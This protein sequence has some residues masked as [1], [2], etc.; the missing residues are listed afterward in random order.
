MDVE[1]LITDS[2]PFLAWLGHWVNGRPTLPLADIV[3]QAGGPQH[4]A[5]LATDIIVG[6]CSVGALASPRVGGI[7]APTVRLFEDAHRLGIRHFVLTQDTHSENAVEFGS[8][9]PHCIG[10]SSESE[11]VPELK[12]LPFSDLFV[13]LPKNSVNPAM[14]TGFED[15]LVAHPEVTTFLVTG[16]CTDICVHQL[17]LYIRVRANAHDLRG[18]RVIV[19]IDCVDTYDLPVDVAVEQGIL[20]HPADLL[21]HVF[22]HSMVLNG[23]EVVSRIDG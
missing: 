21:H 14:G 11:M 13:V 22:L 2:R 4:V 19:P 18:I 8:Y 12:G 10:G 7:V 6:F 5:V 15:W 1:Q 23:V 9:P 3:R 20:P 17:S 16:D